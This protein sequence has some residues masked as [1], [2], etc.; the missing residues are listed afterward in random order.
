LKEEKK[1]NHKFV[2]MQK[3]KS[4]EI[5]KE[6]ENIIIELKK[7]NRNINIAMLVDE[8]GYSRALFYKDHIKILLAKYEIGK[9]YNKHEII[10]SKYLLKLN[11]SLKET[12]KELE[13]KL[14]NRSIAINKLKIEIEDN[15]KR[16]ISLNEKNNELLLKYFDLLKKYNS[17][18]VDQGIIEPF[19]IKEDINEF[20]DMV[21][22]VI[23]RV[24][25]KDN[26]TNMD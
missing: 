20:E 16:I 25:Y 26:K 8:T 23:R 13:A 2:E 6:I 24:I 17:V 15:E 11:A 7:E 1:M 12:I 21:Q 10:D 14:D 4:T 19:D 5:A 22:N 3:E 9:V 18:R